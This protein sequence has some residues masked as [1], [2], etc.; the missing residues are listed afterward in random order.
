[1]LIVFLDGFEKIPL[2]EGAIDFEKTVA[3]FS[4]FGPLDHFGIVFVC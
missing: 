4:P 2:L 3:E 1:M